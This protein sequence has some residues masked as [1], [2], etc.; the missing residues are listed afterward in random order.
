MKTKLLF[1]LLFF[2]TL[3]ISAQFWTEQY[4]DFST[5]SRGINNISIV[6]ANIAWASAYDGTATAGAVRDFTR[7]TDGGTT[8]TSG[9]INPSAN[10]R[11]AS[12]SAVSADLAWS[13][14]YKSSGNGVMG[15]Y[16]TSNGGTTWTRQTTANFNLS[17][18]FPNVVHFWDANNGFCQGDP[19]GGYYELYTTT[20]GGTTWTR[21]PQANIPAPIAG[22]YGYV[23]QIF[24]SGN[25]LWWTTNKGRIFRSDDKGLT[26][27]VYQSPIT[28][29]GGTAAS[30]EISFWNANDG[31]L[32]NNAGATWK[33]TDGA[34]TWTPFFPNTG[35]VFNGSIACIP[36]TTK[37]VSTAVDQSNSGSSY[38]LDG[39]ANWTIIDTVQH[40]AVSFL[41]ENIGYSGGF[42]AAT[43]GGIFK[44]TGTELTAAV[45]DNTLNTFKAFPNPVENIITIEAND[46]ITNAEIFNVLGQSV[47]KTDSNQNTLNADMSNFTSGTY[48]LKV[49]INNSVQTMKLVK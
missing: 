3:T 31:F 36:G 24:T 38:S 32:V 13:V 8:W 23:G 35:I 41:D 20:N 28:D 10:L 2:T 33:T 48:I 17:G 29:F 1:N 5:V 19:V 44:Y 42:N 18:S 43:E 26:F 22:E 49:T 45:N 11:V 34:E 46:T 16:N 27:T 6:D 7:T 47:F 37:I 39:G 21:V 30:G 12:I 15:V 25:R 14:L 40:I 9:S 4:T